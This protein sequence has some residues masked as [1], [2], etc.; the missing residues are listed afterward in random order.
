MSEM[1]AEGTAR[2]LYNNS[3]NSIWKEREKRNVLRRV[4]KILTDDADLTRGGR[5]FQRRGPANGNARS[6][7]VDS[8]VRRKI[9]LKDD[10]ERSL[11]RFSNQTNGLTHWLKGIVFKLSSTLLLVLSPKLLNFIS[12]LLFK[13]LSTGSRQMRESSARFSLSHIQISPVV[14]N[15]GAIFDNNLS[16]EQHISA[17]FKSIAFTICVN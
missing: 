10:A 3:E 2:A 13:N 7:Y 16:T 5:L 4:S 11:R 9:K 1:H 8:L 17:V 15:L 14:L 12:L 6:P